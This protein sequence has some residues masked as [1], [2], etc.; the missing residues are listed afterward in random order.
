MVTS[1]LTYII[2]PGMIFLMRKKVTPVQ[3]KS[4]WQEY[5]YAAS[6]YHFQIPFEGRDVLMGRSD[7][8]FHIRPGSPD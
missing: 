6:K 5:E 8:Y 4:L 2:L 1:P 7:E 3:A